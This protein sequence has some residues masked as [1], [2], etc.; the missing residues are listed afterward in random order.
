MVEARPS[1]SPD[2]A[3]GLAEEANSS[4]SNDRIEE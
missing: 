1:N 3:K 4:Q 2:K